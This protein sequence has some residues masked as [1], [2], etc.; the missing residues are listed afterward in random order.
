MSMFFRSVH[1]ASLLSGRKVLTLGHLRRSLATLSRSLSQAL[2][3]AAILILILVLY[4]GFALNPRSMASR[5]LSLL[6][7]CTA[8][9]CLRTPRTRADEF[10]ST[11]AVDQVDTMVE[12]DLVSAS[13]VALELHLRLR[14]ALFA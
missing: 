4:T 1:L 10:P 12:P 8:A 2:V 9:V 6:A 7:H 5:S 3:P 13:F 14:V 11:A